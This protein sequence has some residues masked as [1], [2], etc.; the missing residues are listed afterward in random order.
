MVRET[1]PRV[2]AIDLEQLETL[3]LS[4]KLYW[5]KGRKTSLTAH[6]NGQSVQTCVADGELVYEF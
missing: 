4:L 6:L 3:L 2:G 1:T 5:D